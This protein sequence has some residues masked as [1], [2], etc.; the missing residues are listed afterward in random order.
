M[1]KS[2]SHTCTISTLDQYRADMGVS[3]WCD[4]DFVMYYSCIIIFTLYQIFKKWTQ[5]TCIPKCYEYNLGWGNSRFIIREA[6][7]FFFLNF[8]PS[9][10]LKKTHYI[11]QSQRETELDRVHKKRREHLQEI[12]RYKKMTF[13]GFSPENAVRNHFVFD[14]NSRILYCAMEKVGSTFWRR[15]F[16]VG[17]SWIELLKN[18]LK[19]I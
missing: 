7:G 2:V 3:G 17:R 9:I 13:L 8:S 15:L 5:C 12:C 14:Q 6:S 18:N 16:Q 1:S 10:D 19:S 11:W 4:T